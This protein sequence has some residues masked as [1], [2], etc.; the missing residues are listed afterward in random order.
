MKTITT[1]WIALGI[2]AL[3]SPLGLILPD[4]FK[5]GSAWGEWDA[6]KF[7]E[8]IGYVP[9]GLQKLGDLWK[10]PMPDY[11]FKGWEEK[12]MTHLS[13][14]YILSAIAGMALIVGVTWLIGK[15]LVRKGN[16]K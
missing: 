9:Q 1:C 12:G 16:D 11:A 10:A 8:M 7:K 13:F 2:L 14:A 5:A 4:H 15:M 6:D 3:L